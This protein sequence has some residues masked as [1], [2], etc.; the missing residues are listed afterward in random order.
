ML[1]K[2]SSSHVK[3]EELNYIPKRLGIQLKGVRFFA[4]KNSPSSQF[5]I[6]EIQ[7]TF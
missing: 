6:A 3:I 7:Y 1:G 5:Q 4:E 2:V